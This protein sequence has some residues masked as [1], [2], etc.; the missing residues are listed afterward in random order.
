MITITNPD[1][2]IRKIAQSGQ[3][4]RLNPKKDGGYTLVALRRALRL[5]EDG[6]SCM[7][8]CTEAEFDALWRDYFDL[9]TD[10]AALR[11]ECGWRR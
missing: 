10:Y 4:F 9:N 6:E 8:D 5:V 3:C 1:F 2:D 7:L 11:A